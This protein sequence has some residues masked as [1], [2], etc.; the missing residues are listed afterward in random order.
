MRKSKAKVQPVKQALAGTRM[1]AFGMDPWELVIIG[2]DTK[3][4]PGEHPLY[5]DRIKNELRESLVRNVMVYGVIEPVIIRKDGDVPEVVDGRQRVRAAREATRRLEREGAEG[6]LVPTMVKRGED[7]KMVGISISL[8]ELRQ[9]NSPL[10]K[11]RSASRFLDLGQGEQDLSD[12]FGVS[13]TTISTWLKLVDLS[14]E[15]QA[16]IESGEVSATVAVQRCHGKPRK[17][18]LAALRKGGKTKLGR[19]SGP[20]RPTLRKVVTELDGLVEN[21]GFHPEFLRAI[22]FVLG[23]VSP[24]EVGLAHLMPTPKKRQ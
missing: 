22:R 12:A 21:G 20:S 9:E 1:N 4:G 19:P 24:E 13:T 17:E 15:V 14:T 18:Q 3:H 2:L 8:N 10:Q 5:D 11:A 7:S 6:V 16:L 23:E